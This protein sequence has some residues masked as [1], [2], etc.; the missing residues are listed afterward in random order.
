MESSV[1][2]GDGAGHVEE[3]GK[4]TD[5]GIRDVLEPRGRSPGGG[6]VPAI[7]RSPFLR[8]GGHIARANRGAD[9]GGGHAGGSA[10][11]APHPGA[12]VHPGRPEAD[13]GVLQG[14][15]SD[16][17]PRTPA[18]S[19]PPPERAGHLRMRPSVP[20]LFGRFHGYESAR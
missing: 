17:A 11:R 14:L 16:R 20:L 3:P 2:C 13:A 9:S 10:G 12:P 5:P 4:E 7:M 19:S 6:R 8:P 15:G 1:L 18:P